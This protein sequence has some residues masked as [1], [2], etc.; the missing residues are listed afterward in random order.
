MAKR[1]VSPLI[2]T[3]ILIGIAVVLGTFLMF[4][5]QNLSKGQTEKTEE[6]LF[7]GDVCLNKVNIDYKSFCFDSDSVN[8][9]GDGNY[10]ARIKIKVQNKAEVP[11]EEFSFK[12][13]GEETRV[14]NEDNSGKLSLD[15]YETKTFE[16]KTGEYN[17]YGKL[18][19]PDGE[20]QPTPDY[21]DDQI[22]NIEI[23]VKKKIDYEGV[24]GYCDEDELQINFINPCST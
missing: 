23:L 13:V 18:Y 24:S 22:R 7:L 17:F 14:F 2:A 11:I 20:E 16:P 21:S 4:F 1:G 19:D 15:A 6:G 12:I 3:V 10:E 5:V 8:D 9:P